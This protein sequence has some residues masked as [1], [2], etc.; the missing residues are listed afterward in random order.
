MLLAENKSLEDLL[1]QKFV[2][3]DVET[4]G[5][6]PQRGDRVIEIALMVT[7]GFDIQKRYAQLVNPQ[8]DISWGA[9][10]VNRITPDMLTG[11]P[12]IQEILDVVL[13]HLDEAVIVGHNIAFDLGFLR[14]ECQLCGYP[15]LKSP[16]VVDT[17]RMAKFFMPGRSG[18]SLA[19]VAGYL[20]VT[21]V[22]RHRALVDVETTFEVF[23]KMLRLVPASQLTSFLEYSLIKK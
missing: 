12:G 23:K 5:L 16:R 20:E 14:H 10:F 2:F 21:Q 13:G 1:K 6:S 22:Q 9:Y 7:R 15:G 18:Y 19:K 11:A 8:R 17:Q 3:L 4:T